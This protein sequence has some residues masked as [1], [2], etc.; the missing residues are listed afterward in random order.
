MLLLGIIGQLV[1]LIA[2]IVTAIS[3]LTRKKIKY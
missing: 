1:P 2:I 3:I